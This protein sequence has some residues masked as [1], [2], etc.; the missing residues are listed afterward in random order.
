M[1]KAAKIKKN[2][3]IL[4]G[5]NPVSALKIKILLIILSTSTNG[6]Y[7]RINLKYC[8]NVSSGLINGENTRNKSD[9][10]KEAIIAVSCELNKYPRAIPIAVKID[11]ENIIAGKIGK[12]L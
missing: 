1:K 5:S 12:M 4:N 10:D 6:V 8:G 11:I 9:K 3:I 2:I 7:E